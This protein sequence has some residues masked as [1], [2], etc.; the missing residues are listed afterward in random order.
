MT[1]W[2]YTD[3]ERLQHGPVGPEILAE[4]HSKGLMSGDAL[5]WREGMS[6]WKPWREMLRE[7][8][9]G[10]MPDDPRAEALARAAEAAPDDGAFRPYAVVERSPYAPPTARID[11]AAPSVVHGGH[12]VY[13]AFWKRFA[14]AFIDN[15]VLAIAGAMIGV[16][17]GG[18]GALSG[19][20]S[21][22]YSGLDAFIQ[23]VS[24]LMGASYFGWMYAS[25]HQASLGKMAVG[26]KV[27]RTD[28]SPIGFWRG[29][30]RYFA[31][32]PSALILMIGYLMAAFTARKQALHDMICDTLVVD[33]H[34]FTDHPEWQQEGLDG[35]TIVI[36]VIAGLMLLG[37]FA[38][39]AIA[40]MALVG[41]S[42]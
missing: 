4:L 30:G 21:P 2:Y 7:V 14:A 6:E 37:L 34:A 41:M 11:T 39:I 42:R 32:I 26:I 33:K 31:M 12:I 1:E 35:V 10:G 28:G 15:F 20:V 40:G 36:L 38:V 22:E 27:V 25:S 24:M 29:F 3:A 9:V 19:D 17:I 23:I 5:V 13:A 18:A 8:I 16:V